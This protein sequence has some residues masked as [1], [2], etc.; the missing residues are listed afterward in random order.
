MLVARNPQTV[1]DVIQLCQTYD[2]L[3]K[4]RASTHRAA[5][6]TADISTL[7]NDASADHTVLLPHIKQFIR[8]EVARQ[9]SLVAHTPEPATSS[10][11]PPLRHVIERQVAQALPTAPPPLP[12]T[13][14]TY[15][16]VLA[17]P[18]APSLSGA[19]P[20]TGSFYTSP[21]P[22]RTVP[23]HSS[24]TGPPIVN[25]WRTFDNRPICFACGRAGHIARHCHRRSFRSQEGA[26]SPTYQAAQHS[27][28][29]SSPV[30]D[31]FS[32]RRPF[33]SR[34]SSSPRR[35]SISPMLR[36]PSPAREEN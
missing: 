24:P 29:V 28:R 25:P 8:E 4:Q 22:S 26:A 19:Y 1:A 21:P 15:A 16:A 14:P 27:Q 7:A 12:V 3:R 5:Q 2:E 20:A 32:T 11:E 13:T 33:D 30:A 18:Q 23:H 10:I 31:S 36:R 34:R 17:R 9:L 35:R 6:D